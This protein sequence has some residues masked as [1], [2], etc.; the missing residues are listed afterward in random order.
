MN[1]GPSDRDRLEELVKTRNGYI[2][3]AIHIA[4]SLMLATE[5][6]ITNRGG[7]L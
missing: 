4:F 5:L 1:D 6:Y 3:D 2:Y 7:G